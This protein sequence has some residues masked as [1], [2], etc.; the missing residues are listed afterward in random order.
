MMDAAPRADRDPAF[1][2]QHDRPPAEPAALPGIPPVAEQQR[3]VGPVV[4]DLQDGPV[5][6][7]PPVE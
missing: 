1:V 3:A 7:D 6:G 4:I 5:V 2:A